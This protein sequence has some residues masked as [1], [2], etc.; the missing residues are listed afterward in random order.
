MDS[1]ALFDI[2]LGSLQDL[3]GRETTLVI[4]KE[5]S[6]NP[7]LTNT[8]VSVITESSFLNNGSISPGRPQTA[9][10]STDVIYHPTAPSSWFCFRSF[11]LSYL[12][13]KMFWV[14]FLV[15]K[16]VSFYLLCSRY[17]TQMK[18]YCTLV[19]LLFPS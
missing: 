17:L 16:Q 3:Q 10:D 1:V 9:K 2:F 15:L 7:T 13:D 19:F 8:P 11:W 4:G 5:R 6:S 14:C 12:S 18:Q